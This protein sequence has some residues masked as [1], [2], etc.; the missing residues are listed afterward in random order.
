[1]VGVLVIEGGQAVIEESVVIRGGAQGVFLFL[2]F[3]DS[4]HKIQLW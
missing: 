4:V 3:D 1:M 2:H